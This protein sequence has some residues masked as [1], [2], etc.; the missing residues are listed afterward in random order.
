[1]GAR[2]HG[3]NGAQ[4][5]EDAR[6]ARIMRSENMI[7]TACP[8]NGMNNVLSVSGLWMSLFCGRA[9][10][11]YSVPHIIRS[12]TNKKRTLIKPGDC[13]D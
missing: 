6:S 12:R 2:R 3:A 1:M 9:I 4:H 10:L 13:D 7:G 5:T 11:T 8:V